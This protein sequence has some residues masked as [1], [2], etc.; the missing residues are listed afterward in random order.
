MKLSKHA[1]A[2]LKLMTSAEKKQIVA[3]ARKLFDFGI[4][5]AKRAE[6]IARNYK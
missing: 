5:S 6:M 1:R 2:R 3:S 4:I